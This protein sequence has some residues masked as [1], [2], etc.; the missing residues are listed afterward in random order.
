MPKGPPQNKAD[1]VLLKVLIYSLRDGV[2][3]T[4]ALKPPRVPLLQEIRAEAEPEKKQ[5]HLWAAWPHKT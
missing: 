5:S 4:E 1:V 2:T 3:E